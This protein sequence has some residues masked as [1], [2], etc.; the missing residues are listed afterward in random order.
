[1]AARYARGKNQRLIEFQPTREKG[2]A[3]P[4]QMWDC[5]SRSVTSFPFQALFRFDLFYVQTLGS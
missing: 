5:L 2:K 4:W 1:M 3:G